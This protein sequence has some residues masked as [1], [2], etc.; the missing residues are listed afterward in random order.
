[1]LFACVLRYALSWTGDE[2]I[3]TR[4]GTGLFIAWATSF[5]NNPN[6][7]SSLA[8]KA[9]CTRSRSFLIGIS[10]IQMVP[11]TTCQRGLDWLF[12]SHRSLPWMFLWNIWGYHLNVDME[13]LAIGSAKLKT[14][15]APQ[16]LREEELVIFQSNAQFAYQKLDSACALRLASLQIY[17]ILEQCRFN[18]HT[19]RNNGRS[20]FLGEP[21]LIPPTTIPNQ[22]SGHSQPYSGPPQTASSPCPVIFLNSPAQLPR[23]QFIM[24]AF[25]ND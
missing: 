22:A 2:D 21:I 3:W 8:L 12:L 7:L 23:S 24:F 9:H 10:H 5:T 13:R 15:L 6:A 25:T 11:N 4:A 17:P 14:T 16:T 18:V 19:N 20:K 1:M